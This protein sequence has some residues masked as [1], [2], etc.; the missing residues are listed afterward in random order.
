[1]AFMCI[2]DR[3]RRRRGVGPRESWFKG[4]RPCSQIGDIGATRRLLAFFSFPPT[5]QR[6]ACGPNPVQR[7]GHLKA[8][9]KGVRLRHRNLDKE[10]RTIVLVSGVSF[11]FEYAA[12]IPSV[13]L[14]HLE[15][16]HRRRSEN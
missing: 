16:S 4:E 11:S 9:H 13:N 7:V 6:P 3:R 1:M 10:Q 8:V 12:I 5:Q 14:F 2:A 15:Q